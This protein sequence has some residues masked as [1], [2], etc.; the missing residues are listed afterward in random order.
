MIKREYSS[1]TSKQRLNQIV[2]VKGQESDGTKFYAY[3]NLNKKIISLNPKILYGKSLDDIRKLGTVV[4]YGNGEEPSAEI[5]SLM[6][7]L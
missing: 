3:L 6:E 7:R 1:F 2:L 5:K 4:F